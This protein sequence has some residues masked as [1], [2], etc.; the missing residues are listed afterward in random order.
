M[1]LIRI[2]VLSGGFWACVSAAAQ[3]N[4]TTHYFASSSVYNPALVGDTRF[5]Q[6]NLVERI[7]PTVGETSLV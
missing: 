1:K 4:F 2:I 3:E 7:Q 5:G 6:F